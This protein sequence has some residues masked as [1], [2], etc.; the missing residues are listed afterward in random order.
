[1]DLDVAGLSKTHKV[2]KEV[3]EMFIKHLQLTTRPIADLDQLRALPFISPANGPNSLPK[4]ESVGAEAA[5]LRRSP[6]YK[7]ILDYAALTD[8]TS[9]IEYI[10]HCANVYTDANGDDNL[11]SIALRKLVAIPDKGNKARVIAIC[12]F[13]TQSLL[14]SLES[15]VIQELHKEFP[16]RSAFFSHQEGFDKIKSLPESVQ[17]DLR[18]LDATNWTDNLPSRLQF[19]YLK[20]KFGQQLAQAWRGLAADCDW[21]LGNSTTHLR[22]GKGQGMGT[23]GSFIIASATNTVFI[24]MLL[25]HLYGDGSTCESFYITVGDDM[26]VHD[27]RNLVRTKFEEIGV[28]INESKSK[29]SSGGKSYIEF[30]SRNAYNG[31]D[32]SMVSPSLVAKTRRQPFYARTLAQHLSERCPVKFEVEQILDIIDIPDKEKEKVLFLNCLFELGLYG[33]DSSYE[34]RPRPIT[35]NFQKLI[36]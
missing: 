19:L 8:N 16:G 9:V 21:R 3:E 15:T 10:E 14:S 17:V 33:H 30:V 29:Q 6:L 4:L 11:E 35:R 23:K 25:A 31:L 26:V 28:P 2:P 12:D 27:P 20:H 5:A 13:F 32:Y 22:Y 36:W 7:Y 18:S 34:L 24:D 1:V